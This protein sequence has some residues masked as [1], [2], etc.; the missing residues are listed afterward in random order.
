MISAQDAPLFFFVALNNLS[1]NLL[2][3]TTSI[4]PH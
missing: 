2:K 1:E 3:N 4:F